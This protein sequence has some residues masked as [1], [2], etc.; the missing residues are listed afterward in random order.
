MDKW[1]KFRIPK[2]DKDALD[3]IAKAERTTTASIARKAIV[4]YL[5]GHPIDK[6]RPYGKI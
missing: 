5:K 1:I 6:K 4:E 3:E 2:E